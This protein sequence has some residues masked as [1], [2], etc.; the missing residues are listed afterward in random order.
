MQ[1]RSWATSQLQARNSE[2]EYE[3]RKKKKEYEENTKPRS[4]PKVRCRKDLAGSLHTE[5]SWLVT[6]SCYE[7]GSH[8]AAVVTLESQVLSQNQFPSCGQKTQSQFTVISN[9]S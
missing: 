6:A 4:S 8:T 2:E 7:G 1:D 5:S 9:A 3:E